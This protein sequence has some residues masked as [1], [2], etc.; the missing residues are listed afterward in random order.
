MVRGRVG[1]SDTCSLLYLTAR[2]S[3]FD[4][5][6]YRP[7]AGYIKSRDIKDQLLHKI[8]GRRRR[9]DPNDI[10]PPCPSDTLGKNWSEASVSLSS[11]SNPW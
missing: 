4:L 1:D 6:I 5:M 8:V 9:L 7:L 3:S 10:Y 2:S 11:P